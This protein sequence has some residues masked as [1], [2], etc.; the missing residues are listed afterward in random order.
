MLKEFGKEL[1]KITFTQLFIYVSI[2]IRLTLNDTFLMVYRHQNIVKIHYRD[3]KSELDAKG[4]IL[5]LYLFLRTKKIIKIL[6][7]WHK[8]THK[9]SIFNGFFIWNWW[10]KYEW[11]RLISP[12]FLCEKNRGSRLTR[13]HKNID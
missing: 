13:M 5:E 11:V 6:K 10:E 9:T 7:Y 4:S 2:S 8:I 3:V 12:K 1:Q